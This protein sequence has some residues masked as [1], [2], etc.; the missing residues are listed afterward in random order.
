M[1]GIWISVNIYWINS[2]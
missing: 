2:M 1:P